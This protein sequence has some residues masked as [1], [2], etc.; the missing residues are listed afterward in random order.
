MATMLLIVSPE[1]LKTTANDIASVAEH[2]KTCFNNIN[3]EV[4]GTQRYWR[5]D[6]S[7]QHI[8][9][10]EEIKPD[11]ECVVEKLECAPKDLLQ[12]A[13]LYEET[14]G[15]LSEMVRSLPTDVFM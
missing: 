2:I 13:G 11:I 12:I 7:T 15:T 14:E 8:S 9:K 1:Q 5:G 4:D 3:Q 10:Y 6:A